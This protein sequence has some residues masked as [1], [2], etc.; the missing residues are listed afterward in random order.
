MFPSTFELPV[1]VHLLKFNLKV[2][3]SL[4]FHILRHCILDGNIVIFTA[5]I[6]SQNAQNINKLYK[7]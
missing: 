3:H 2:G 6:N 1:V 7:W 5:Y 4:L